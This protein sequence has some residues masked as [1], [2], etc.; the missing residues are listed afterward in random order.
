MLM[1]DGRCFKK[2]RLEKIVKICLKLTVFI[3]GIIFSTGSY[4]EGNIYYKLDDI[5]VEIG[6]TMPTDI[7]KYIGIIGNN[8]DLTIETN[9][10]MDEDGHLLSLGKYNYYIVYNNETFKYSMLTNA[11]ANI[12]IVDTVKPS[13]TLLEKKDFKYGSKILASDIASCDDLSG[14]KLYFEEEINTNKSGSRTV[15]IIAEDG[16]GNK[17]YVST[18]VKVLEKPV[19]TYYY[20]YNYDYMNNH[21]NELNS[22]LSEEEKNNLRAQIVSFA[23]QFIGNPYVYGGTSLTNG[24][25]CSGFTMSIYANFGYTL[26]RVAPHQG[27]VGINISQDN[28]LPGDLVVYFYPEGGGHVGI[29]A[30]NGM[31]VHAGTPETG[32][33]YAPV[34]S[35]YKV[36]RRIIY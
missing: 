7:S 5:T 12:T 10:K 13:I 33:V 20:N 2:I 32:I 21:N 29:Y 23:M 15:N 28:L 22:N 18:E 17:S 27:S 25:D 30:G 11:R 36:Y 3:V 34:F 8:T 35:G 26:P 6:D 16:A 14:C 9:A 31:M 24:A 19:Y 4:Y 1:K